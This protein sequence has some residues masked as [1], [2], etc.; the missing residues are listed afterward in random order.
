MGYNRVAK[1][2]MAKA[3]VPVLDL[4]EWVD[5]ACGGDPYSECPSGCAELPGGEIKNCF[6]R[7]GNVHFWPQGYRHIATAIAA[8]VEV[9]HTG[10]VCPDFLR[11]ISTG[12]CKT[13]QIS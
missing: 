12:L 2:V 3:D 6:Q 13:R 5:E 11:K 8:A 9:L 1:S 7:T 10:K 4:W